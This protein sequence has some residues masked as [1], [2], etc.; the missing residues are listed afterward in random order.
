MQK[1]NSLGKRSLED[2]VVILS[3]YITEDKASSHYNAI[4]YTQIEDMIFISRI[5]LFIHFCIHYSE[6]T[7]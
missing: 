3:L 6:D 1:K 5:F 7:Y 2:I 4:T